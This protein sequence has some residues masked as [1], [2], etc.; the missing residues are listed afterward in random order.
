MFLTTQYLEEADELADRVAVIDSG[1]LVA[2][3][4]PERLKARFGRT[5]MVLDHDGDLDRLRAALPGREVEAERPGRSLVVLDGGAEV[6]A[7]LERVRAAGIGIGGLSVSAP[8]LEDVY[9]RL[10]GFA[11]TTGQD[12]LAGD[13]QADRP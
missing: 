4:A 5:R 10:T 2:V 13:R 1:T 12:Q 6:L 11:I 3:D 9:L 8:S 7:V